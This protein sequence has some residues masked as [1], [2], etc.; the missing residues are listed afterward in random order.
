MLGPLVVE[1]GP[2]I[3]GSVMTCRVREHRR[4]NLRSG[5]VRVSAEVDVDVP[6]GRNPS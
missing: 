4:R 2:A 6:A 3:S 5:F 1:T